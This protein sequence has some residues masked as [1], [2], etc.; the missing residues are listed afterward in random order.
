M[1]KCRDCRYAESPGAKGRRND[2]AGQPMGDEFDIGLCR[3]RPPAVGPQAIPT[4]AL[5]FDWCGEARG[6]R[7]W[8]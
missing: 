1:M 3:K 7:F 6:K 5:D 4:I 2:A 8:Q